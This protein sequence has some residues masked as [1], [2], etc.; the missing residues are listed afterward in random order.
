MKLKHLALIAALAG[1]WAAAWTLMPYLLYLP[2]DEPFR[3]SAHE[4]MLLLGTV[5][6]K[7]LHLSLVPDLLGVASVAFLAVGSSALLMLLVVRLL[8]RRSLSTAAVLWTVR[9]LPGLLLW[10]VGWSVSIA[11]ALLLSHLLG[12][13]GDLG[14]L[15][16]VAFLLTLP[17]FCLQ[18]EIIASDAPPRFWRPGWPGIAPV[19]IGVTVIAVWLLVEL[20][21]EI[22]E[23]LVE[24]TPAI[25]GAV[26]GLDLILMLAGIFFNGWVLLAWQRR[27]RWHDLAK[28]R[29]DI[30]VRRRLLP[31]I[32]TSLLTT[33]S[34]S[35]FAVPIFATVVNNI[36]IQPQVE[37]LFQS[38]G[39]EIPAYLSQYARISHWLVEWWWL[40]TL[41]LAP[42]ISNTAMARSLKLSDA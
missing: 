12:D 2:L 15:L 41:A 29:R 30:V 39:R 18:P 7:K 32:A 5:L 17:F 11:G 4:N 19:V 8:D 40:P 6:V 37:H 34:L 24:P 28:D 33:L 1:L 3:S 36:F 20:A 21:L 23:E 35:L 38:Q 31:L 16:P 27:S 26:I 10:C 13:V 25:T 22:A 42:W 9:T 14:L